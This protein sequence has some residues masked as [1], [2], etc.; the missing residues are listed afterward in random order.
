MEKTGLKKE[1][2]ELFVSTTVD[3]MI[4]LGEENYE[5]LIIDLIKVVFGIQLVMET[6]EVKAFKGEYEDAGKT[7]K[8]RERVGEITMPRWSNL[9][10]IL[11]TDIDEKGFDW[12]SSAYKNERTS[13][14]MDEL[15]K[16]DAGVSPEVKALIAVVKGKKY[17]VE[18]IDAIRK[19]IASQ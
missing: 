17:S 2:V 9:F 6:K 7:I 10:Q 3:T 4:E 13:K 1:D 18:Q 11:A 16:G 8:K 5:G 14:R 15:R 12:V 19:F